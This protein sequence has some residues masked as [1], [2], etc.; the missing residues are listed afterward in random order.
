MTSKERVAMAIRHEEPDR[1]P[2]GEWQFGHEVVEAVLGHRT[3]CGGNTLRVLEAYWDGRRDE[4]TQGRM[5]D[6]VEFVRRM[7]WDTVLLHLVIG[8]DT[9]I[10]VPEKIGERRWR[11][12]DGN[13]MLYSEETGRMFIVEKGDRPAAPPPPPAAPVSP[14]PTDSELELIRYVVA[15]LGETHYLMSAPL[16]GHPTLS[17]SQAGAGIE[18]WVRL[19][20]DPDAYAE[21]SLKGAQHPNLRL[22]VEIAKREGMDAI[23]FGIDFGCTTGPFMSNELF[24]K[25]VFPGLEARCKVCHDYGMPVVFHS[26]GNNRPLVDMMID[27]G[28]DVYQSIQD[29]MDIKWVKQRYGDRLTVWGGISSGSLV[30][31]TPENAKAIAAENIRVCKPGGGFILGSSHSI[32]PGAKY[33]N[34]MA[35]LEAN[36][37]WGSYAHA[38]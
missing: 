36:R 9:P 1:V 23:S 4:A 15:E 34:Y 20:E 17:F 2:I 22:G 33:E 11:D 19:Y 28:V 30:L 32:M 24:K 21:G 12:R 26:C 18:Q 25:C 35:V 3:Y 31:G 16:T 29:E 8:R 38:C 27:A 5:R 10:S 7:N 13:I 6:K 14:E 37:E